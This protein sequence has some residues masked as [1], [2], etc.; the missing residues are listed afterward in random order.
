MPKAK[1]PSFILELG[2]ETNAHEEAELNKRFEAARQLYNACLSEAKRRLLLLHQSK[3]FQKARSM[4]K[5][6]NPNRRLRL[7]AKSNGRLRLTARNNARPR[8]LS[9]NGK[10]NKERTEAFKALN[11]KFGFT[12]YD[13]HTY[14]TQ[15]RKSWISNH[16]DSATAQKLASRAFKAIQRVAFGQAR[17][18][19]FKGKNQLK[20]VEGKTN[21]AGIRYKE[22]T[23][24]IQWLGLKLNCTGTIDV[25]D[26]VVVHGLSR[27]IKYCRIVKRVF[28]G[29]TRFFVQLVL[30]AGVA[31]SNFPEG[32]PYQKFKAKNKTV[33][34][35]IGPSTIAYV[36]DKQAKLERFCTGGFFTA[37]NQDELNNKQKE[38]RY[39]QRK[40]DRQRRA[41]NPQNYNTNG[42]IKIGA[43]LSL[44]KGKKTWHYSKRYLRT[45]TKLAE[46][47]R[48]LT[49]HRKSLHGNLANRILKIGKYIRTEKLS[50]RAFQKNYGRSVSLR[51]PGMFMEILRRKAEN[52]GG[53]VIEFSTKTTK[54]SQYCHKCGKYTKKP[55]SQRVP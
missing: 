43:V 30:S 36:S 16:L 55:L 29:K 23:E 40:L 2:L 12:E 8:G 19:R 38:I 41:N 24:Q 9:V 25:K 49:A 44:S 18:V 33:G 37:D 46:L 14:A 15:T 21:K 17:K 28:N 3:A 10:P 51:A 54:L 1:T 27:P 50:Y 22:E 34:L 5:T 53:S 20:S 35:D 42:T 52:A 32:V 47:Q 39:L 7:T 31:V 11:A 4:P 6:A 48:K 45:K 13:I 26:K